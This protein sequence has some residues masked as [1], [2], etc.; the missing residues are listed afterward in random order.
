MRNRENLV[1]LTK[2]GYDKMAKDW[3]GTRMNFWTELTSLV[4]SKIKSGDRLLDLGCGNARFYREVQDFDIEYFGSDISEGLIAQAKKYHPLL[5]L[6][7]EDAR[8]TD[9]QNNFLLNEET[10]MKMLRCDI[11]ID[12]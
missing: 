11:L 12:F 4:T 7:A 8:H 6:R 9:Y 3:A 1:E 2:N 10:L 5:D